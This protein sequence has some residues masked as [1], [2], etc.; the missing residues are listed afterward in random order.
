LEKI[1][2]VTA[3]N[4]LSAVTTIPFIGKTISNS[5]ISASSESLAHLILQSAWIYALPVCSRT[6]AQKFVGHLTWA[7]SH[8]RL[9]QC[10]LASWHRSI[11]RLEHFPVSSRMASDA[12]KAIATACLPSCTTRIVAPPKS[13]DPLQTAKPKRKPPKDI[14]PPL[15]RHSLPSPGSD[16]IIFADGCEKHQMGGLVVDEGTGTDPYRFSIPIPALYR[17]QQAAEL[18]TVIDA[19][20]LALLK[21]G[22]RSVV[23]IYSD[24]NTAIGALSKMAGPVFKLRRLN[25][26]LHLQQFVCKP[27]HWNVTICLHRVSGILNPADAPSREYMPPFSPMDPVAL[28]E[29]YTILGLSVD[30]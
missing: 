3:K 17:Q 26:I 16:I 2:F 14:N 8:N 24:S 27:E 6:L 15:S 21:R 13:I 30:A 12:A 7:F 22:D 25:S 4:I 11:A 23:H 19:I 29:V 18:F 5:G 20:K 1:G 9:G 10:Y 28:S